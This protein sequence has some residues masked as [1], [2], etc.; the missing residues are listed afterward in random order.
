L[1][2]SEITQQALPPEIAFDDFQN[3][4]IS[5]EERRKRLGRF[6]LIICKFF[7]A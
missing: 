5:A 4:S 1:K 2:G 7:L 6:G 3:A